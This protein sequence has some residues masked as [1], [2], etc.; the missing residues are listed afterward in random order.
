MAKNRVVMT[1]SATPGGPFS[2]LAGWSETFYRNVD[3]DP[4]DLLLALTNAGAG[5]STIPLVFRRRLLLTPGWR[6][7]GIKVYPITGG[8]IAAPYTFAGDSAKG[9]Y[10]GGAGTLE[11]QPYD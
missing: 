10:A 7:D 5:S 3:Q 2:S 11:Q 1:F 8:R 9:A 4:A 6:V